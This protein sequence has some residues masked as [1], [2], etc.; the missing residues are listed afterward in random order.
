VS[1][2]DGADVLR[3]IERIA[4]ASPD[5]ID[6]LRRLLAESKGGG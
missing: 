3:T 2:V 1:P 6:H 4:G 5:V